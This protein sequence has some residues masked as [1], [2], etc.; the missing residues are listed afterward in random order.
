MIK[1]C[2]L[3]VRRKVMWSTVYDDLTLDHWN[4]DSLTPDKKEKCR[5]LDKQRKVL[6]MD[7]RISGQTNGWMD[8]GQLPQRSS[9][10]LCIGTAGW[11]S[12]VVEERANCCTTPGRKCC[13]SNWSH[14]EDTPVTK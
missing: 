11:R 3:K 4:V 7:G 8:I 10:L 12:R 13:Y 9:T 2:L 1:P 5:E 6:G 14:S